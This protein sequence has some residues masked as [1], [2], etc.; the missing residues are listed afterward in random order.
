[1]IHASNY[2]LEARLGR[3][4]RE[5][6]SMH[7]P[8]AALMMNARPRA[9]RVRPTSMRSFGFLP[10]LCGSLASQPAATSLLHVIAFLGPRR[11]FCRKSAN[12]R[13]PLR[14][15]TQTAID[16]SKKRTSFLLFFW[17]SHESKREGSEARGLIETLAR[18]PFAR[19]A[20]HLRRILAEA[21]AIRR[22]CAGGR[23]EIASRISA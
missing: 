5:L 14:K 22:C 15:I 10:H 16:S 1:M 21:Q 4:R 17:R 8:A 19:G 20:D 2:K 3:E 7:L 12:Q 13:I 23:A 9:A 11:Q 6:T 18:A